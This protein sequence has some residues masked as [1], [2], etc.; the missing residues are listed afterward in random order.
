MN[1]I[2]NRE[3]YKNQGHMIYSLISSHACPLWILDFNYASLTYIMHMSSGKIQKWAGLPKLAR[4]GLE[5]TSFPHS[6]PQT[7]I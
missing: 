2:R 3:I 7:C 1:K 5:G 6:D 4:G